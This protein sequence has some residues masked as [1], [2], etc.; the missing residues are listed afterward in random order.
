[1]RAMAPRSDY[2]ELAERPP[3]GNPFVAEAR[4][5]QGLEFAVNNQL[6]NGA[7][8]CG[9]LLKTMA[10]EAVCKVEI[11]YLWMGADDRVLV[12]RGVVV[13]ASS[14]VHH[15][16]KLERQHPPRQPRPVLPPQ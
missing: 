15:F 10:G 4:Q 7:A 12:E 5:V 14:G 3:L 13:E 6:S 16:D 1:M 9:G 2:V 11:P 8:G